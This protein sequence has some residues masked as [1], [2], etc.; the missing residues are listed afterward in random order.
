[1]VPFLIIIIAHIIGHIIAGDTVLGDLDTTI[2]DIIL[3]IMAGDIHLTIIYAII[4][5]ATETQISTEQDL[6]ST[7]IMV[8][9]K[10]V[11]V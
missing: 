7:Q 6:L 3:I 10:E 11:E 1:M 5:K 2:G 8:Q 4:T 9:D